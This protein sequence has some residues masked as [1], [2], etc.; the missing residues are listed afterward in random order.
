MAGPVAVQAS[1]AHVGVSEHF[2]PKR[3]GP[4]HSGSWQVQGGS[5]RDGGV[6]FH[7][8][9]GATGDCVRAG[10]RLKGL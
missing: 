6:F 1:G 7:L 3:K 2:P 5:A 8:R 4:R 10:G 9:A